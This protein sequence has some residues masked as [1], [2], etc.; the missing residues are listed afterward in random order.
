MTVHLIRRYKYA[1]VTDILIWIY[2]VIWGFRGRFKP[3]L[4]MPIVMGM[5]VQFSSTLMASIFLSTFQL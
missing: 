5:N 4:N 2:L 1:D 3:A